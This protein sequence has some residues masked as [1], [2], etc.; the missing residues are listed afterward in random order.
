MKPNRIS[1]QESPLGRPLLEYDGLAIHGPEDPLD[2]ARGWIPGQVP[3][4]A[5]LVAVLGLGLGYHLEALMERRP[6]AKVLVWEPLAGVEEVFQVHGSQRARELVESGRVRVVDNLIQLRSELGRSYIYGPGWLELAALIPPGYQRLLPQA[7]Q[8]LNRAVEQLILRR[9]SNLRT[10]LRGRDQALA[11]LSQN[12]TRVLNLPEAT[13]AQGALAGR[14]AVVAA[15]GPS[16]DKNLEVLKAGQGK[17]ALIS[18]GTVFKR[19]VTEGIRPDAV[20]MIEPRDRSAQ[21]AGEKALDSTILAASSLGHPAH[22][23]QESLATAVFHPEPWIAS[24]VGDWPAV[25]D[26]GNVASA[27]F[28]LALLWGCE[29]I[30][31]VGQDLA[32]EEG[33]RYSKGAKSAENEP[34]EEEEL[35]PLPG[36]GG[37]TVFA[38]SELISYL[39]WYE[40]SAAYLARARPELR[41]INA[42]EGGAIIPGFK[43]MDLARALS[44]TEAPG[45]E[46]REELVRVFEAFGRDPDLIRVRLAGF[47]REAAGLIQALSQAP[48]EE[49]MTLLEGSTF[50]SFLSHLIGPLPGSAK[51]RAALK[52]D[53]GLALEAL[54][55]LAVRLQSQ[56]RAA[57]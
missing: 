54:L 14:P 41:L 16:L 11:N 2:Q 40:E 57:W 53:L 8:E 28:T 26:G 6:E 21:V 52:S 33:R 27:G 29:P 13:A 24:L 10:I 18:V 23:A 51:D 5:G 56:A 36:H 32:Y 50:R 34:E 17:V 46:A 25:P 45:T 38:S 31:L 3:P 49:V 30:I 9:R 48:L 42:T 37:R 44:G 1:I 47:R 20:V 19:L 7:A 43:T 22:L 55:D 12:L 39:S 35:T 15:A 4:R